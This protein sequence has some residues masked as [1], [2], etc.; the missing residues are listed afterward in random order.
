MAAIIL[1][2]AYLWSGRAA[3]EASQNANERRNKSYY[4]RRPGVAFGL[5]ENKRLALIAAAH[6]LN[7]IQ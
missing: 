1:L 2:L 7:K 4:V 3:A 5:I 6:L